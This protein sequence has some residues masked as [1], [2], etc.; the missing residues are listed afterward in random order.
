MKFYFQI[1]RDNF[2]LL[3]CVPPPL[4]PS[5]FKVFLVIAENETLLNFIEIPFS[6]PR[7]IHVQT[8]LKPFR[9]N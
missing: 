9:V 2:L 3:C 4:H 6:S 8:F 5:R 1:L 7:T